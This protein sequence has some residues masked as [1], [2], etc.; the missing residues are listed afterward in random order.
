MLRKWLNVGVGSGDSDF[1]ADDEGE[2]DHQG[3]Q[4]PILL[5]PHPL[6]FQ[7]TNSSD[8]IRLACS[9]PEQNGGDFGVGIWVL[10]YEGGRNDDHRTANL[11][12][13]LHKM[14]TNSHIG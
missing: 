6:P 13:F 2:P 3:Q 14:I 11:R 10:C 7:R 8:S 4:L 12:S 5:F 1:S 9:C